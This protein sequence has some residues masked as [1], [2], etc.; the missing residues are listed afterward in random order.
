[1][2]TTARYAL[3][4]RYLIPESWVTSRGAKL[5][6]ERADRIATVV[7]LD[8]HNAIFGY[9]N[10]NESLSDRI[11]GGPG[12]FVSP[13][14]PELLLE[15]NWSAWI[16]KRPIR[17]LTPVLQVG[18]EY[19]VNP[20]NGDA[21]PSAVIRCISVSHCGASSVVLASAGSAGTGTGAGT[22]TLHHPDTVIPH[23]LGLRQPASEGLPAAPEKLWEQVCDETRPPDSMPCI[24]GT[25][26]DAAVCLSGFCAKHE[27][28]NEESIMD[29]MAGERN[30]KRQHAQFPLRMNDPS[31]LLT[32]ESGGHD[33][34]QLGVA[35]R[36]RVG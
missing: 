26:E 3:G 11:S 1:M 25:C 15:L 4:Q 19:A 22:I 36:G 32:S 21:C 5:S 17:T 13:T 7:R 24:Q 27:L 30:W 29:I 23:G 10:G 28:W 14:Q 8:P 12:C 34:D 35:D 18:A 2:A 20:L 6:P 16:P 33:D 31:A 9:P